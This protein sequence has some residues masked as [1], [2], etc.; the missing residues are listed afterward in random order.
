MIHID[1]MTT[2][3]PTSFQYEYEWEGVIYLGKII[4]NTQSGIWG[5]I[6]YVDDVLVFSHDY[7]TLA[8]AKRDIHDV[9][10]KEVCLDIDKRK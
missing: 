6:V 4:K 10:E 3:Q 7:T 9:I 8:Q 5:G 2:W 1:K